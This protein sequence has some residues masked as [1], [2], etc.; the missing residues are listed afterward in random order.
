M[1]RALLIRGMLVGL[2]AGVIGFGVARIVGEPQVEKAID[3]ESSVEANA[4]DDHHESAPVSRSL[5]GSAGL[6]A[7]AL[8]Y[9][10]ALGGIFALVFALA[11]GRL[12]LFTARGTAAVLG[13]LGFVAVGVVPVLKYPANPPAIGDPDTIG[14]RTGWYLAMLLVSVAAMVAAVAV[15][16]RLVPRFGEWNATL[17][18]GGAYLGA[19]LLCYGLFPGVNE[20]PQQAISGVV[21]AVTDVG[22]TF[23]PT[24]LWRFRV[25]SLGIQAAMWATVAVGF[26]LVAGRQL[27]GASRFETREEHTMGGIR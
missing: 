13:V 20:V 23:P 19:M 2:I 4:H 24:V 3:F 1:I 11:Y 18:V 16:R 7:G 17:L 5:Q 14:Q 6:G 10:V 22:V 9:G 8:V 12:P 25:A 26:G 27:E 21:G 15:R